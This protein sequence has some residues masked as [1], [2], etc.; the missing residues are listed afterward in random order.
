MNMFTNILQA[1]SIFLIAM[2]QRLVIHRKHPETGLF[3]RV[4]ISCAFYD[5]A[6]REGEREGE[7]EG[8]EEG[9]WEWE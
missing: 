8:D 5:E 7:G 3:V 6:K 2:R 9:T 1:I 4:S